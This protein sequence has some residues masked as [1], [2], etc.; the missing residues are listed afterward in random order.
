MALS[1]QGELIVGLGYCSSAVNIREL[2]KFISK[3][4]SLKPGQRFYVGVVL[5]RRR[6]AD[7]LRRLDDAAAEAAAVSGVGA[8]RKRSSKRKGT[9][10]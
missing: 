8:A 4:T 5:D 6:R 2:V 7:S 9:G 1:S 3:S 10:T